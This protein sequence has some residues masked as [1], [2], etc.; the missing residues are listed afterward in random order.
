MICS[1]QRALSFVFLLH[2]WSVMLGISFDE[3]HAGDS[4]LPNGATLFIC[5]SFWFSDEKDSAW[6][7]SVWESVSSYLRLY[8]TVKGAR[9]SVVG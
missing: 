8:G 1:L 4:E 3:V 6:N 2:D 9:G 5:H 7:I